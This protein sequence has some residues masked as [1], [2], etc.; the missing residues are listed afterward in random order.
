MTAETRMDLS[1]YRRRLAS[2]PQTR[3]PE[4]RAARL[5][6]AEFEQA[7]IEA[8]ALDR[9]LVAALDVTAPED[10]L[11]ELYAIPGHSYARRW[12]GGWALAASLLL[13]FGTATVW[14]QTRLPKALPDYV[15]QHYAHDGVRLQERATR[16]SGPVTSDE[17]LAAFGV[18]I[19]GPL[20]S[21]VR[22][23]KFCPTPDGR[24]AHLVLDTPTG[25]VQL[26]YIPA[27]HTTDQSDFNFDGMHA[28]LLA[29]GSATAALIGAPDQSFDETEAL[30]RSGIRRIS[31]ET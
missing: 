26:I 8:E 20:A 19:D 27:A 31:A 9:R 18:R 3:D 6:G 12:T 10:L 30:V 24:G 22:L 13:A 17:V 28:R 14:W 25:A 23:A 11:K 29:L 5:S 4:L 15:A 1:E 2:D 21:Q 7:A 16:Q